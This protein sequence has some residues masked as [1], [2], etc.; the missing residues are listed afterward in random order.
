MTRGWT[1]SVE[2]AGSGNPE[3]VA[4]V[5][6]AME[7]LDLPMARRTSM[8]EGTETRW[9][10]ETG[11]VVVRGTRCSVFLGGM[12]LGE[13][14]T[15][16]RDRGRRNVLAVAVAKSGVHLQRLAAAFGFGDEYLRDLRRKEEAGGPAA[17]LLARR[18]G[19]TM[20]SAAQRASWREQFAAGMTPTAV[21]REQPRRG[22]GRRSTS[23]VRREY[24]MWVDET[25]RK[26]SLTATA[27][28][29]EQAPAARDGQL[30]LW[31]TESGVAADGDGRGTEDEGGEAITPMTARPVRSSQNVQHAGAWL[32]LALAA[33]MGL[34]EEANRAFERDDHA[35]LRI[36]LDA[37]V[38]A[39]AIKQLCVE[40][41]RRLATP[42]G[43]TLLRAARVPTA[44]GV[45]QLLGRL[46]AETGGGSILAARMAGRLIRAARAD[47]G[48]AV[49]YVDNHLRPY[50]GKEVVR[51]GWRMQDRRVL[52]GTSDYYVH[53]EDG[54]PVYR[55]AVPSHDSL[56][57]QLLPIA[58]RLRAALGADERI[59]LAFDRAGAHA[60]PLAALR[61]AGF[62]VVTYERKPYTE[63]AES[64]F[65]PTTICGEAVLLHES[66]QRNL[67][68]GRGR[69]R[70]IAIRTADGRQVNFLAS[71]KESAERLVEILWQRWR[72]ENAFKHGVERWG[73]NQLDGRAVEPYPP[74]TIIPNPAR[75][76]LD[77]ALRIARVAEGD[78][79]RDLARLPAGERYQR[80]EQDLADALERQ[81]ELEALRPSTPTHAPV[82]ET[83]LAD[84]LVRHPD[85]Y[86][87]VLDVIRIVCA[88]A[89]SELASVLAAHLRR[90]REAKKVIANLFAA[91]GKITVT[92]RA[93]HVRLAPAANRSEKEAIRQL[94]VTINDRKLT[95]PSDPKRL[96]LVFDLQVS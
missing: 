40:G 50:S 71:S 47:E 15:T 89:E 94:L 36:A 44:T 65:K 88:N 42:S 83:A 18:G 92:D 35:G 84:T 58:D 39:L 32:L 62:E 90:P 73:I 75:R 66:R 2:N 82:E 14:D 4:V 55:I 29:A 6:E 17:L 52:P 10:S 22:R 60:E 48:P 51:K 67:G 95:L 25:A 11:S 12:L 64:K 53:D 27:P 49:F 72:Q 63:I 38:C 23:S 7:A 77:R 13:F 1:A 69:V 26:A 70:R 56:S 80:A 76:R 21:H 5:V 37:I 8:I 46:I 33:E 20:V 85:D 96:P 87:V 31:S 79:R 74:G 54:D 34:H 19:K 81:A 28:A 16:D 59:L 86:K 3:A 57:A 78:A 24:R 43:P 9:F 93:I 68:D 61:D 30:A 41:V 45:R 91:P